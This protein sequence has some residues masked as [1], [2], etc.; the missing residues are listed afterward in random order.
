MTEHDAKVSITNK[1]LPRCD[2][3]DVK[4]S[5][6]SPNLMQFPA[7]NSYK[8]Q[9]FAQFNVKQQYSNEDNCDVMTFM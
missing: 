1:I 9:I 3:D 2:D 8:M 7:G 6:G 5:T 4:M